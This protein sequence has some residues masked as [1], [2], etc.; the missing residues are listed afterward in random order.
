MTTSEYEQYLGQHSY[1][2]KLL[3]NRRGLMRL[4]PRLSKHAS[5]ESADN[6]IKDLENLREEGK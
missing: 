5:K 4:Y 6:Q 1:N 3:G 2:H